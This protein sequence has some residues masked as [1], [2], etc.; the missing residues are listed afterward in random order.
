MAPSARPRRSSGDDHVGI[1]ETFNAQ[2]VAGGTGAVR[3][4]EAEQ[5]RLDL[6]DRVLPGY[7][8]SEFRREHRALGV[9]RRFPRRPRSSDKASAVSKLSANREPT[10][11]RTTHTIG[12]TASISCRILRPSARGHLADF[13]E[14]AARLSHRRK[15]APLQFGQF[16]AVFALAVAHDGRQQKPRCPPAS[17]AHDRPFG[18]RSAPRSAGRSPANTAL[19]TRAHSKRM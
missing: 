1:E 9:A 7:R 6:L 17:P 10:P 13:V 8:T 3:G 12:T 5:P 2:S 4:V 18:R 11:S 19:P 16:L 14:L 15:T